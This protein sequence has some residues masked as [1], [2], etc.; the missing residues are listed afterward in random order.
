[1][2]LREVDQMEIGRIAALGGPGSPVL[3]AYLSLDP[4][5][6]PDAHVRLA[7]L[8][9]RLDEAERRLSPDPGVGER[10]ER[11]LLSCLTRVRRALAEVPAPEHR[12]HAVAFFCEADGELHAYWLRRRPDFDVAAS[13]RERAA[14][15]PLVEALPGSRWAIALVSRGHSRV[16]TGTELGL[17]EVSDVDGEVHRWHAQGGWSQARYQRGIEKEEKDHVGRVCD[18]LFA[19]HQRRPIDGLIVGGPREIWPLVDER[20]HPYLR[21][22]LRGH[23]EIDVRHPSAEE[24]LER[25]SGV[26]S[27]ERQRREGEA[28]AEVLEG[29][30]TG[31]KSVAGLEEVLA[32]LEAKRVRVLLLSRGAPDGRFE[33]AVESAEKQSA[34]VLIVHGDALDSLGQVAALLRY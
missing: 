3:S 8:G 11:A 30:G 34:E 27:G 25:A 15:E 32:A 28:I 6:A 31:R 5:Q 4:A 26:M 7:E 33:Q 22:R 29:L 1:M 23:L 20:L 2:E 24:V 21:E 16:F 17:V 12:V 9:A 18:R 14:I 13:F 10:E 19:L